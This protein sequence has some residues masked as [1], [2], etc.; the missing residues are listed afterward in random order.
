M[1]WQ[2]QLLYRKGNSGNQADL[3]GCREIAVGFG[4]ASG[5]PAQAHFGLGDLDA[6]DVE[7]IFPHGKGRV[8]RQSVAA[9]QVVIVS[10]QD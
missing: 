4:Y 7:V 6:V 5:Q 9:N 8:V 2:M 1:C 3:I 10:E